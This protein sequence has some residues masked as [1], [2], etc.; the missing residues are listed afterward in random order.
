MSTKIF[1]KNSL[2]FFQVSSIITNMND[3][4]ITYKNKYHDKVLR[5][6]TNNDGS[7][8]PE[9]FDELLRLLARI[10]YN[11]GFRDASRNRGIITFFRNLFKRK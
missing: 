4:T 5:C 7:V 2:H 3:P 9:T 11:D 10:S 8:K 1:Y 6:I